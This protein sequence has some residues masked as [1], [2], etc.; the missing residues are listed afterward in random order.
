MEALERKREKK[1]KYKAM[2]NDAKSQIDAKSGE[3][4][5]YRTLEDQLAAAAEDRDRAQG[6]LRNAQ[7]LYA[8]AGDGGA[9][10]AAAAGAAAAAESQVLRGRTRELE[11]A[12]KQAM[13]DYKSLVAELG[14]ARGAKLAADQAAD[15]A[16]VEA[17]GLAAALA[18]AEDAA[19]WF[20]SEASQAHRRADECCGDGGENNSNYRGDDSGE[21][22][23]VEDA[24]RNG[25]AY[26]RHWEQDEPPH[27][28]QLNDRNDRSVSPSHRIMRRNA[29]PAPP[30]RVKA[31]APPAAAIDE[32]E[33]IDDESLLGNKP[34][35]VGGPRPED[36]PDY[37]R[38]AGISS[39]HRRY[40]VDYS[41][42]HNDNRYGHIEW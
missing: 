19:G 2:L 27:R 7:Q 3:I 39:S 31:T 33:R 12:L 36:D 14:V 16:R 20:E 13:R 32:E 9:A 18:R 23:E 17:E 24:P 4:E 10:T 34:A 1:R 11:G 15:Q 29:S 40:D 21:R 35:V 38:P 8:A 41:R 6:A 28:H 26:K 30:P 22:R 25:G 42:R 37:I 5:Y